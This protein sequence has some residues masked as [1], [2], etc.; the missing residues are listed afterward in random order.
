MPPPS[1]IT[2]GAE[3][4]G[5]RHG[6]RT[7]VDDPVVETER[8]TQV[9]CGVGDAP[10]E[11]VGIARLHPCRGVGRRVEVPAPEVLRPQPPV[12]RR[13]EPRRPQ[14]MVP[15]R[16][17]GIMTEH[18]ALGGGGCCEPTRGGSV[19][20]ASEPGTRPLTAPLVGPEGPTR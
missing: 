8:P 11:T 10:L 9:H 18:S 20:S 5:R 7:D 2:T 19:S 14:E 6:R 3:V 4:A 17:S 1:V 13:G 15:S 16:A 12:V